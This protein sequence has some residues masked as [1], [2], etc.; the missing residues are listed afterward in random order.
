[1]IPAA[2]LQSLHKQANA[3]AGTKIE[4]ELKTLSDLCELD[5]RDELIKIVNQEIGRILATA[6]AKGYADSYD[7][8][9]KKKIIM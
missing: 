2:L 4:A 6:Y 9:Q 7:V 3:F 8:F 1:M 5:G